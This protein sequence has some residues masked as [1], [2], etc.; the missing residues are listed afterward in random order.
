MIK[1]LRKLGKFTPTPMLG[2]VV[3]FMYDAKLKD[4]LPYWDKYPLCIPADTAKGGFLGWNL[5]YVPQR[6]RKIILDE[7]FKYMEFQ[8]Q[9][10][11]QASYGFLKKM[12]IFEDIKPCIKHY[13]ADHVRSRYLTINSVYW[14]QVI[15]MP[16]AQWQ[17]DK[18]YRGA[19]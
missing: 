16:T 4:E 10:R 11:L 19:K 18:P 17:K 6:V 14:S 12:S 15:K 13:L 7:L 1:D 3:H 8:P 2:T 5:H 9:Q